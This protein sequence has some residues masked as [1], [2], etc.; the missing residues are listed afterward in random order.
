MKFNIISKITFISGIVFL[1]FIA[2][3][4]T[5]RIG[6]AS[7]GYD[8]KG[9]TINPECKTANVEYFK[10]QASIVQPTLAQDLTEKLKDKLLSQTPLKLTNG[11]GDINFQGSIESYTTQPMAPQ[12][13][14][15]VT[16]AL[17][18]LSIT[19]KVKYS[20]SKD[21]KWDYETNFTRYVDY[22]A[23]KNPS[24]IE[25]SS[26]YKDMLDHLIQDIFDRAFVNW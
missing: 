10:N 5:F 16:A 14:N 6:G 8:M 19:I 22:P 17:N 21:S 7:F 4:C 24:D 1:G 13:G 25:G 18:R 15:V 9:V 11:T 12:G 20:N 26:D 3:G 2:N 23:D